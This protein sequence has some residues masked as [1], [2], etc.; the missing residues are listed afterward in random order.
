MD[1]ADRVNKILPKRAYSPKMCRKS[2]L[3][4]QLTRPSAG[5]QRVATTADARLSKL[6]VWEFCFESVDI[7]LIPGVVIQSFQLRERLELIKQRDGITANRKFNLA[8]VS[9]SL[10]QY[11]T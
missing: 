6:Y 4:Q 3:N 8:D 2:A 9:N 11:E 5:R 1:A 10:A 7:G